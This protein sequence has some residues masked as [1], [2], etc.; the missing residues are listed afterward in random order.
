LDTGWLI[1]HAVADDPAVGGKIAE[2]VDQEED[3]G[4]QVDQEKASDRDEEHT[5]R[6]LAHVQFIEELLD[7]SIVL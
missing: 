1:D 4:H 6:A 7:R 3:A 2:K 5:F